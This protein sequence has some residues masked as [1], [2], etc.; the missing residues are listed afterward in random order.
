MDPIELVFIL[1]PSFDSK[2]LKMKISWNWTR[3]AQATNDVDSNCTYFHALA[4]S[5]I[6]SES[7]IFNVF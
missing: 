1:D 3:Q 6:D 4:A 7:Y 5:K 2:F